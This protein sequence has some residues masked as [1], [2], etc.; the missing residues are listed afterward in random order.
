MS[1]LICESCGR[2]L[3]ELDSLVQCPGC[4]GL[5]S[6]RHPPPQLAGAML[7]DLFAQ[8][9]VE[10]GVWRFAEMV[11]PGVTKPVSFPE[12]N[13]PLLRRAALSVYAGLE[14]V[15]FKHEGMNPTGSFKD[16][17]MTVGMTQAVRCGA[18]AVACASTGN[19]S[20]SLAAYAALAGLPAY[21]L[22]PAG[23]IAMGKLAQAV[24]FGATVLAVRGDFDACMALVREAGQ[25][26]GL[27]LLNS[28]NPFR[29]E[30][31]KT[32][33][34]E[35]LVDR[36][37]KPPDW[38]VLPGGNLGNVSAF[39]KALEEARLAGLIETLPRLAV[40]QAEGAAPFAASFRNGFADRLRVRA[41]TVASAIR[42]G[43]PASWDRAVAAIR[44]TNGVVTSV[45]DQE[46]LAAHD[47]I[48]RAGVGSEPAS[49]ASL[50]GLRQL[51]A[52]ETIPRDASVVA[53]LTGHMLKDTE[54]LMKGAKIREV[55]PTV[56]ALEEELGRRR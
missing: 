26:L 46:I 16:R 55:E 10:S 15:S 3:D 23:K 7:R 17:G 49:A 5:L 32:I 22:V 52:D 53:V 11:L 29:L 18:R 2:E 1:V 38:I 36:G 30:G 44:N 39:G 12:G 43:D 6:L 41:E 8:R 9:R 13:T 24:G 20:A 34:F 42:I 54:Q 56:G 47:A 35:L 45:S 14:N 50:A 48:N 37:W 21:V 31:Q 28:V 51:V 33:V 4:G 25:K 19:T 40:I 27:Y